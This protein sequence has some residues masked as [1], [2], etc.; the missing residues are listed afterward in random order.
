MAHL[1]IVH[2]PNA[3]RRIA[4]IRPRTVIGRSVH[5]DVV[6]PAND[7]SVSREH[8]SVLCVRGDYFVEDLG[9][10]NGT[11][12]NGEPVTARRPLHDNDQISICDHRFSFQLAAP[13]PEPP[14]PEE[15]RQA[16]ADDGHEV[17]P[18]VEASL[19][20]TSP[21]LLQSRPA[22][23]LRILM[24]ISRSLSKA[25]ELDQLLPRIMDSLFQ[26]FPQ[27]DRGFILLREDK[28]DR[29]PGD[30]LLVPKVIKTRRPVNAPAAGY[31]R[32]IVRECLRTVQAFLTEDASTDKRFSASQSVADFLIRSV[33]CAPLWSQE[34]KALGVILLDTRERGK[35][36]TQED[37]NLLMTVA[38]QASVA[39]ENAQLHEELMVR[40]RLRRD[41]ELAQE[42]QLSFLPQGLPEV[43]GYQFFAHYEPAQEV[44]GDY[45]DFLP[46]TNP[47]RLAVL[48]GD[49]SGKGVPAA[50]LMAKLSAVVRSCLLSEPDPGR[51]IGLLNDQLYPYTSQRNSFITFVAAFLDG[52]SPAVTLV[53]AGHLSPLVYRHSTGTLKRATSEEGI[54]LPLGIRKGF[55]YTA[56]RLALEPGD[57]F[58]LFS[59]GITEAMDEENNQIGEEAIEAALREGLPRLETLGE[60]IVKGIKRHA[61]GRGQQDDITLVCFSRTGP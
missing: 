35:K 59:D 17:L 47:H 38:S 56:Q 23:K 25:L 5:C 44:G 19:T 26:L 32:S 61:S 16:A 49:V 20:N 8:A 18:P 10:V 43:P 30:D 52:A 15:P 1:F 31:S 34:N 41:L 45:Y 13:P 14:P 27:A 3:N 6:L 39:L 55:P 37:L 21:L 29:N 11:F 36:F 50:L 2:G 4:L 28:V 40:E 58:L 7:F 48:L 60:R 9:S 51:A 57:C 24:E 54:G 42:V 46:L 33:I 53:N 12:V 22:E